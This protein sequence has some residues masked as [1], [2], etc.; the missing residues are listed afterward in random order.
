LEL[1]SAV[2]TNNYIRLMLDPVSQETLQ[3]CFD[4]VIEQLRERNGLKAFQV[5]IGSTT[6]SPRATFTCRSSRNWLSS[7]I[8]TA[9]ASFSVIAPSF[10]C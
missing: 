4:Q 10:T 8:S 2:P 1:E 5:H 7:I 6:H 3:P 9:S